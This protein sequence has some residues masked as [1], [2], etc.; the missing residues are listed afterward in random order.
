MTDQ[1]VVARIERL[2]ERKGRFR[3]EAYFW[4]LRALEHTRVHFRQSGH[5]S[6]QELLEGARDL[7]LKEYGPMAFEVFS[8]WGWTTTRDLG[9][10]VF[11]LIEEGLLAKQDE[12]TLEDFAGG[13]DF[14]KAFLEEYRW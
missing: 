9:L 14:R 12:D 10:V 6:G 7:A 11:D 8:H 2:A 3:P 5:V 4:M 1:Q 13:F